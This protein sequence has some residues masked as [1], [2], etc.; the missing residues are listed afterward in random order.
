MAPPFI[1]KHPSLYVSGILPIIS[2]GPKASKVSK[3]LYKTIL[4][5]VITDYLAFCIL[6]IHA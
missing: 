2:A 4:K 5:E 1:E 3:S 6:Y